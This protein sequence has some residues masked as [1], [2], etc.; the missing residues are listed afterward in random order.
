MMREKAPSIGQEIPIFPIDNR[1]EVL[2]VE[3]QRTNEMHN[4]SKALRFF[5]SLAGHS[6]LF[7]N[8]QINQ[9]FTLAGLAT[10]ALTPWILERSNEVL[11][12]L[13]FSSVTSALGWAAFTERKLPIVSRSISA[14]NGWMNEWVRN[15]E[16]RIIDGEDVYY[17]LKNIPDARVR[18]P[19]EIRDWL[20][21]INHFKKNDPFFNVVDY[22][23]G[24]VMVEDK[25]RD[26]EEG[27]KKECEI[28]ETVMLMLEGQIRMQQEMGTDKHVA[29]EGIKMILNALPGA[30]IGIIGALA[31]S[32][33]LGSS[34]YGGVWGIVDDSGIFIL[35]NFYNPSKEFVEQTVNKVKTIH[36]ASKLSAGW[37]KIQKKQ[38]KIKTSLRRFK[39]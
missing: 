35:A 37:E 3:E 13:A 36:L 28:D 11:A 32:R 2:L 39:E 17:A 10:I 30:V 16:K 24:I 18:S 29:K 4:A 7:A 1:W 26:L 22:V 21:D 27:Q 6:E 23:H 20:L 19:K 9:E 15:K 14:I 8:G 25:Y 33:C 12:A 5:R 38:A 31:I 34:Q